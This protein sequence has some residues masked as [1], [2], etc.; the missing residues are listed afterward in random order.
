[1][2]SRVFQSPENEPPWTVKEPPSAFSSSALEEESR[3]EQK[4]AQ[5][6]VGKHMTRSKFDFQQIEAVHNAAWQLAP[7]GWS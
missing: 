3:R 6:R 1:M 2:T 4:R 5:K 7:G